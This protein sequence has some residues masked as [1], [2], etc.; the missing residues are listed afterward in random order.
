MAQIYT[1]K[2]MGH[3]SIKTTE[4]HIQVE[5]QDIMDT[6][7]D[8]LFKK[9]VLIRWLFISVNKARATLNYCNFNYCNV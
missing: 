6:V 3:S 9:H 1:A 4:R 8:K 5:H 2:L 7:D